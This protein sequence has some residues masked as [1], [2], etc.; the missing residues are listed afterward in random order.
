MAEIQKSLKKEFTL[1]EAEKIANELIVRLEEHTDRIETVGSIRR[2]KKAV[3]DIDMIAIAKPYFFNKG[4][5]YLPSVKVLRHGAKIISFVYKETQVD[6]YLA[7]DENFEVLR[8][9]RT[10][11]SA[12]NKKLCSLA[13]DK[14]MKLFANGEGLWKGMDSVSRTEDGILME[15]LGKVIP[16]EEREA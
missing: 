7:N 6:V 15:L 5:L 14:G 13:I 8:L 16:P 2:R 10:G 4:V 12:H 9:I 11:S 1:E 3:H